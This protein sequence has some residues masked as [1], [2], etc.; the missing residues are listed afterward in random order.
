[1]LSHR[2][3]TAFPLCSN[4]SAAYHKERKKISPVNGNFWFGPST[5][6]YAFADFF[7]QKKLIYG[8]LISV[9]NGEEG[10]NNAVGTIVKCHK[11]EG[12]KSHFYSVKIWTC[13]V[14]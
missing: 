10:I 3:I 8:S 12:V 4:Q 7:L 1:M 13:F 5:K 6:N 11:P 14:M 2:D 9:G